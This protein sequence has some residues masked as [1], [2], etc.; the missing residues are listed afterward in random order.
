[1]AS[2]PT[3][4]TKLAELLSIVNMPVFIGKYAT[5]KLGVIEDYP[6]YY[7]DCKMTCWVTVVIN[8]WN[9]EELN[10]L[11]WIVAGMGDLLGP[12]GIVAAN[13]AY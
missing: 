12:G 11:N 6:M 3:K 5:V 13:G 2:S 9:P 4:I 1:M 8:C 10:K 7:R